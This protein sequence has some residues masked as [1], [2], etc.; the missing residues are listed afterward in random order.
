MKHWGIKKNFTLRKIH[1]HLTAGVIEKDIEGW[2]V[3]ISNNINGEDKTNVRL[4]RVFA[5]LYENKFDF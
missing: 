1:R 3:S 4:F 5:K 2:G